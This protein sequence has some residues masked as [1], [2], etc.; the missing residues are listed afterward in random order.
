MGRLAHPAWSCFLI[1]FLHCGNCGH[2]D[3][4]RKL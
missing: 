2:G 3:E 1:V 4:L